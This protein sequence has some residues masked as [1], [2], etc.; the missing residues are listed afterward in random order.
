MSDQEDGSDSQM[1]LGRVFAVAVSVGFVASV[2][3]AVAATMI[4]TML[5]RTAFDVRLLWETC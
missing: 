2:A 3:A 5:T 4:L 1:I